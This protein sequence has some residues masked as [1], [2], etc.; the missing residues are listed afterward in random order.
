M[1]ILPVVS[2]FAVL[3]AALFAA[4]VECDFY[5]SQS[6][7]SDSN[8]GTTTNAPFKTIDAALSAAA[9]GQSVGVFA[10][11][12]PYPDFYVT[13][14]YRFGAARRLSLVA[15]DGAGQTVI[16]AALYEGT[17]AP[18]IIVSSNDRWTLFYG[19]T[20]RG[21][22]GKSAALRFS[23]YYYTYFHDCAFEGIDT[24]NQNGA[25]TW[26]DCVLDHCR[27]RNIRL[28]GLGGGS[29]TSSPSADNPTIFR[30]CTV[31]DSI[32]GFE[33]DGSNISL[34][35]GSYFDNCFISGGTLR[36]LDISPND[37]FADCTLLISGLEFP[38]GWSDEGWWDDGGVWHTKMPPPLYGCLVGVDGY[39][40]TY[41]VTDTYVTNHADGVSLIDPATLRVAD[42][43]LL[44]YYYGYGAH[45]DRIEMQTNALPRT[46]TWNGG[47][48]GKLSSKSW[49]GGVGLH[50]TP[51]TGDTLVFPVGGSFE[52]DIG[53]LV[54]GGLVFESSE[55]VAL[56]GGPISLLDGGAG[57]SVAG[58]GAVAVEMPLSFGSAPTSSVPVSVC[59]GG[60]LDLA[61]VAGG[62]NVL[63]GGSGSVNLHTAASA[64]GTFTLSNAVSV[65][66]LEGFRWPETT[67]LA[68]KNGPDGSPKLVL[69]ADVV[70]DTMS[71][72]GTLQSGRRTYGSSR[73]S[74]LIRDDT[75]FGGTCTIY[76]Q[77]PVRFSFAI[78]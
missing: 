11:S 14:D 5:V 78:W 9:R 47:S 27:I 34:S 53:G 37:G 69:G 49:S 16:D 64:T 54:L 3:P 15:L 73:S 43:N 59:A 17:S 72:N 4:W 24:T 21:C 46:L 18:R 55:A 74:A 12:Y 23:P 41:F 56:T 44:A 50:V 65:A 22:R 36:S 38:N 51:F 2:L 57:V 8:P 40:N 70:C 33:N 67:A 42:T 66:L 19:F 13:N 26:Y 71:I 58:L 60:S 28:T 61:A 35:C 39:T 1:R 45:D 48:S 32:I 7:G 76:V 29:A 6:T 77:H 75:H 30:A 68:F 20:I 52:N 62:A 25:T 10:G 31:L 63:I